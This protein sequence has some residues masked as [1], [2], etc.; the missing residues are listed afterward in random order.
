MADVVGLGKSY[1]GAAIVK[2][3]ERVERARPLI[4][5]PKPLV[6]MWE[7][8][9][10]V[11]QLNAHVLPMSLLR[12]GDDGDPLLDDV[13]YKDRDFVLLDESHNFRNPDSQ[14]YRVLQQ[15]LTNGG[16]RCVL[17]T[18]TPR[19]R[20]AWD[21][22]HQL[23]LFHAGDTTTIPIDPPNLRQYFAAVEEG[24]RSLPE[25]LSHVLIRRTRAHIVRWYGYD[26]ETN[27][28]INPDDLP[29]YRSN[30]RRA[31]V[32]VGGRKQ[33]FPRRELRTLDYSIEAT[34][35]GLYDR[36]RAAMGSAAVEAPQNPR[37]L[38]YARYGLW[39]YVLARVRQR[40]PYS[41]LQRAGA[42]LHGLMRAMLFKRFE[43]SVDAFRHT[44]RRMLTTHRAFMLAL[45]DGIV[46]AGEDAAALLHE[47]EQYDDD[48]LLAALREAG[49]RYP[50]SDFR[51]AALRADV[52]HDIAVLDE[53]LALVTPIVPAQDAKLQRLLA[54][55]AT[56][57]PT[58]KLLIFSQ[59]SDTARY[60][61]EAL[62]PGR[63]D[64]SIEV[65]YSNERDKARLVARFAPRANPQ[66]V[67]RAGDAPIRILIAT[68]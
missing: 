27:A 31:Y 51:L 18:A 50:A 49:Q 66:L 65:V 62:N 24:Q 25:L 55:I 15:Y 40:P 2:H 13:R 4:I 14:R 8:Y 21:I 26:A 11:Y 44:L 7:R 60:L 34:Y 32:E 61:F 58:R 3:F 48:A 33:S 29:L 56:V 46:P 39:N 10:E 1:I 47:A 63:R 35:A 6:G 64:P 57:P 28:R 68:D 19:T 16:R 54:H 42:N 38:C 41:E 30:Q 5:C 67:L 9:N 23:R 53:M 43:S 12:T 36:L 22:Y 20:N 45:D 52:A 37:A 17:L 59:Y